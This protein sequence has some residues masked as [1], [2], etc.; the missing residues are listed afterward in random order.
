MTHPVRGACTPRTGVVRRFNLLNGKTLNTES[1]ATCYIADTA[2]HCHTVIRPIS[3][4][5]GHTL[6]T[7]G[8]IGE[9]NTQGSPMLERPGEGPGHDRR[10]P[11]HRPPAEEPPWPERFRAPAFYADELTDFPR[12]VG[13]VRSRGRVFTFPRRELEERNRRFSLSS[14]KERKAAWIAANPR[15]RRADRR[16][17]LE[18]VELLER[19][20]VD[21]RQK[22]PP[23]RPPHRAGGARTRGEHDRAPSQRTRPGPGRAEPA[24]PAGSPDCRTV[25]ARDSV[26]T[27]GYP[28]ARRPG[29]DPGHSILLPYA[30]VPALYCRVTAGNGAETVVRGWGG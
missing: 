14:A 16:D 8:T 26:V 9:G 15:R 24:R 18:L 5:S 25:G 13:R 3:Y 27:P 6:K 10:G 7:I 2:S 11:C 17:L 20:A 4:T 23:S 30:G 28:V 1:V 22:R 12:R 19:S 21:V 29:R